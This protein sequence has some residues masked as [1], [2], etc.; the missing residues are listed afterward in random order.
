MFKSYYLLFW[1]TILPYGST[2]ILTGLADGGVLWDL[3]KGR[4]HPLGE[5]RNDVDYPAIYEYL[6]CLEK[7]SPQN[8]LK[9]ADFLLTFGHFKAKLLKLNYLSWILVSL[10]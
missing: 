4:M 6:N 3:L 10:I 9:I 1:D 2:V 7:G 5:Y 8:I